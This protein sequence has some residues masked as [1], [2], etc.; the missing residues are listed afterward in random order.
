MWTARHV[1]IL[2]LALA[3]GACGTRSDRT[4]AL[5]DDLKQ[6]LAAAAA[7]S[8]DLASAPQSYQ[9]MRFV[10]TV[11]RTNAAPPAKRITMIRR[12]T[13]AAVSRRPTPEVASRVMSDEM[14]AAVA[15]APTPVST[16]EAPAAEPTTVHQPTS[17]PANGP[18]AAPVGAGGEVGSGDHGRGGGL[19][20]IL[21]GI[22]AGVVIRGAIGGVDKC[23]PR[24]DGRAHPTVIDRPVFGMPVPTGQ[25]TFPRMPRR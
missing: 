20:G 19:G 1:T 13:K 12:R 25:P 10:S 15:E 16:P 22:F 3:A 8:G 9:A 18:S 24:T 5:P 11:E 4:A 6:D 23:D 7:S 14:D 21:G 17:E 2:S